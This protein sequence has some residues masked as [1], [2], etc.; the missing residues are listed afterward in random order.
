VEALLQ[1]GH[2]V[3]IATRGITEDSF[4]SAVKRLI[5]DREDE[6]QLAERLE[7]KSYD[8]VYDNLCYSSNAAKIICEVLRGKTKK[9]VMTSS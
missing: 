8:I 2:D 6:K 5:V 4:G 7:D 1:E 3:T 9:Y